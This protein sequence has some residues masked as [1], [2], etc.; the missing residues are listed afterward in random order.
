MPIPNC[1]L[2]RLKQELDADKPDRPFPTYAIAHYKS[3]IAPQVS[4]TIGLTSNPN[5]TPFADLSSLQPS[6]ISS[7]AIEQNQK[8]FPENF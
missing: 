2:V 4:G 8:R 3:P 6:L 7:C 1:E 5:I